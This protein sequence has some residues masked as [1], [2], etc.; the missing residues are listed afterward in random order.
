M[1][2]K[3]GNKRNS[4]IKSPYLIKKTTE[5]GTGNFFSNH[6]YQFFL[7][8]ILLITT[9]LYFKT[10][11][12]GFIEWDDDK[13]ITDN[14]LIKKLNSNT[15]E[16][17]YEFDKHT[18]FTLLTYS[19][20]Y[21]FNKL[22]P[23]IYH[24]EN[25]ILHLLN[26]ILVFFLIRRVFNN[27]NIAIISCLLFAIHPMRVE[28]VAWVSERKDLLFTFFSLSALM[29][30]LNYIN[31]NLKFIFLILFIIA[32]WLASVSKIQAAAIPVIMFL[33]DYYYSR[34]ISLLM[35]Y[36]KFVL[37]YFF[38]VFHINFLKD[39]L[40]TATSF[41]ILALLFMIFYFEKHR[42]NLSLR[43]K[44]IFIV[45]GILLF[46][47]SFQKILLTPFILWFIYESTPAI[48]PQQYALYREKIAGKFRNITVSK[49]KFIIL[50]TSLLL[51]IF[52]TFLLQQKFGFWSADNQS[53]Q[54][55][56]FFDRVFMASY[57]LCFYLLNFIAPF[58][59]NALH[60]YPL[61]INGFLPGEYYISIALV[62]G[63][64]VFFIWQYKKHP[65]LKK[66][67]LFC[68][69]FFF[70]N[71]SLV[72]H[73]IPIEGRLVAA[74]RYSYFAYIGLF[75][76]SGLLFE[77]IRQNLIKFKKILFGI[78]MVYIVCFTFYTWK[79]TDAWKDT[80]SLFTD[81][82]NKNP[83]I[84]FAHNNLGA[85]ML[86]IKDKKAAFYHLNKAIK[87]DSTFLLGY[88]NRAMAFFQ[89]NELDSALHDL[90]RLISI[91]KDSNSLSIEYNDRA[92]IK[93]NLRD[94]DGA[95]MD[96]EKAIS[97][98]PN[99][100]KAYNNRGWY[101]YNRDD[102]PGAMADCNKALDI[103]PDL[104]DAYSNRGWYKLLLKDKDGSFS[105]FT[106]AAELNP[107]NERALCNRGIIKLQ[108][109]DPEGAI[110]DFTKAAELNPYFDF[111]YI[112]RGYANFMKGNYKNSIRDYSEA[113]KLNPKKSES[114]QNRGWAYLCLKNFREALC[115][116]DKAVSMDST[117]VTA[118][119]NRGWV[120][121]QLND[122]SDAVE[123]INKA[124]LMN[125]KHEKSYLYSAIIS[126][127]QKNKKDA[128]QDFKM[129]AELNPSNAEA[130]YYLG[131]IKFDKKDLQGACET[132][133]KSFSLG[134]KE[135]GELIKK[136]C[137][138]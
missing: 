77:D 131:L 106:K 123:D 98:N 14:F 101:K 51:F 83:D 94:F 130:L 48:L 27:S 124:L 54:H 28:S 63:L 19:I 16:K 73:I 59:L 50:A 36:E 58:Y 97:L 11:H 70:L 102:L 38:F 115:D 69:L 5:P 13:Q 45:L 22:S 21:H 49:Y 95:N 56:Y 127:R 86:K 132:W 92:M 135:A 60:P 3:S 81:V 113:I 104:D 47:S 111:A 99:S 80:I 17:L 109:N 110:S 126:Y 78:F 64:I 117:D 40:S 100:A 91:K 71:I 41:G 66:Q 65:L 34:K 136:N 32:S 138:N 42:D 44:I 82:L 12:Y 29:V 4:K 96:F 8:I 23:F 85:A 118:L 105:D 61:K 6:K 15:F 30:Y 52:F 31:R 72:L 74:D 88:Y 79:R 43:Q 84:S 120:K 68:I 39:P 67:F 1:S 134:Y 26:I 128:G 93:L 90:N 112:N 137:K 2:K 125:P 18:S 46:I 62:I 76:L 129:V 24:L 75:A 116:Y 103:N 87:L 89:F 114:Y 107:Y 122:I 37:L 10:L 7:L 25:I 9:V 57:A 108:S 119:C 133:K 35:V 33:F 121:F 53:S 20:D 55:F